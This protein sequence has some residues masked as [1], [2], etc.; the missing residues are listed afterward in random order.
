MKPLK[1]GK[2]EKAGT[3]E[4]KGRWKTRKESE[5]MGKDMDEK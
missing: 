5:K 1:A 3:K 4:R 2:P